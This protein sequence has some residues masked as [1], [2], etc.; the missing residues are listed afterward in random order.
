M[1]KNNPIN[2]IVQG[3]RDGGAKYVTNYPGFKSSDIFFEL[4]GVQIASSEKVA[5]EMAYGGCI[6]GVRSV[7]TMKGIGMNIVADAY[8]HSIL[9]GVNAGLVIIITEDLDCVSS[10]EVHDSRPYVDLYGG[11]WFEPSSLQMAYDMAHQA[12]ELSEELDVPIVFRLT[13][14]FFKLKESF[15]RKPKKSVRKNYTLERSKF[16]SSWKYR[17]DKLTVKKQLIENFVEN[18]YGEVTYS[19]KIRGVIRT[20]SKAKGKTLSTNDEVFDIVTY[21]IP[22]IKIKGFM[23]NKKRILVLEDGNDYVLDK[24]RSMSASK[25]IRKKVESSTTEA[26]DWKVWSNLEKLFLAIKSQD[27]DFV[28]GD[29]GQYTDE[30]TKTIQVCLSMGTAIGIGMGIAEASNKYPLC[31]VG[32][33]AFIFSSKQ[34]LEEAILM[35]LN[36]GI[37]VIDNQATMSTGGQKTLIDIYKI[38][39]RIP[40]EIIEFAEIEGERLRNII[41]NLK[42]LKQLKVI[43]IKV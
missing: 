7:V 3:L 33:G 22:Y 4:G 39:E 38:D 35:N 10:P 17:H 43:Y 15:V 36:L 12:F 34:I 16:I 42:D 2:S 27:F 8:V 20:G 23:K 31:I 5:F 9:N 32:D 37:L 40:Y 25:I 29:E 28:I 26:N 1:T 24:V 21:P 13:N 19:H 6:S 18:F 14:N 41:K 11:L 30:S